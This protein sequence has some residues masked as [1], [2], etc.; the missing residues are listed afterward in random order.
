[1]TVIITITCE[2][3]SSVD[4]HRYDYSRQDEI[5]IRTGVIEAYYSGQNQGKADHQLLESVEASEPFHVYY[6]VKSNTPFT[7]SGVTTRARVVQYRTVP[8]K[9][10]SDPNE[11][12]QIH[13]VITN[14][15]N[16]T[17][18]D[19]GRHTGPGKYK[20]AI[21]EHRNLP[22]DLNINLGFYKI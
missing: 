9:Q 11:R 20:K 21:F 14:P 22:L 16:E 12:L 13:L 18:P 4:N 15:V 17:L 5:I 19:D 6:R 3:T 1:M 2:P 10:N 8:T 7:Y